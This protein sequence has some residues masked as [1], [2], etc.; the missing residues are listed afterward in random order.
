MYE[1]RSDTFTRPTAELRRVM[2]AAEVGDDVWGEDPTVRALE[3]RAAAEVGKEAALFMPSGTM[4]NAVAIRLHATQGDEAYAHEHSHVVEHEVGGPAA[5]W[6][7]QV[8]LLPGEAGRIDPEALTAVVPPAADRDDI[9]LAQ[10][11]LLCVENT[12]MASGGRVWP[13]E[14]LEAVAGRAHELGLAVHMDGARLF[15]AAVALGVPAARV[16]APVDTVQFCLSKGLGAPIGSI[17]AGSER[18]VATARRLRKLLGGGMRQA[19][20]VAAAGLHVLDH[21]VERLADDH[22]NARLLAEGLEGARRL[23]VDP[24][25][26]E[27]NIVRGDV[28]GEDDDAVRICDE[29][30]AV[31]V[32]A[33]P[34]GPRIVRF[35]T[36]LEVDEAGVRAALERARPVLGWTS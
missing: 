4:G 25:T 22:A 29:L 31:G 20:V 24:S 7:V 30:E 13:L 1:L 9:H 10:P 17:L 36:S 18:H 28:V 3:E 15:N 35:V 5:L 12:H 2:A 16:A 19:G 32:R 21:H 14:A 27:T 11:R 34:L 8:R 33:A 23:R 6:G 26:V